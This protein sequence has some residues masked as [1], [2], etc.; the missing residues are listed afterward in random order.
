M[1]IHWKKDKKKDFLI[2]C[3]SNIIIIYINIFF[4]AYC[5][6]IIIDYY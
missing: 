5:S 2:I 1:H 3:W 6:A 4:F